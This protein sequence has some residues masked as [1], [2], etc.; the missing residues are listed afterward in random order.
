[1]V[2]QDLV[3]SGIPIKETK[4]EMVREAFQHFIN[5]WQQEVIDEI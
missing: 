5:E 4:E 2:D 1:M 3:I